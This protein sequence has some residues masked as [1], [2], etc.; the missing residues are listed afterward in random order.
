MAFGWALHR[1]SDAQYRQILEQ[2]NDGVKRNFAILLAIR[3]EIFPDEDLL[4]FIEAQDGTKRRDC[5]LALTDRRLIVADKF[6]RGGFELEL[7]AFSEV[8][9]G[10]YRHAAGYGRL[11]LWQ[12][13][14]ERHFSNTD[15]DRMDRFG[16]HFVERFD[17]WYKASSHRDQVE[18]RETVTPQEPLWLD[19]LERLAELWQTGALNDAEFQLAKRRLLS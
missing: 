7:I 18:E 9:F 1:M 10:G 15:A 14:E 8:L 11:D 16:Q 6:D 13:Q 2:M 4:T 19:E 5:L 17:A 12:G 3:E